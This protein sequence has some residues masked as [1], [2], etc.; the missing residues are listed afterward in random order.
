[1]NSIIITPESNIDN[2]L[3]VY[4]NATNFYFPEGKYYITDILNIDKPGI[5]FIGLPSDPK[6]VHIFQ[7]NSQKDGL[8][9][10]AD[11]F[12]IKFISIHV[13]HSGKVALQVASSNNSLFDS[14]YFYGNKT[15]FTVYFAGPKSLTEG[16]STL[17]GYSNNVLDTNNIFTNNVVYSQWS[18]DAVSYSLQ[19]RGQFSGNIIR[20]GKLAVYM[21]KSC[22]FFRNIIYDST[23]SSIH[24]S[25]PS[26]TI[27]IERN[28]IYECDSSG[29]KL[30]N[31]MEHGP[32]RTTPYNILIK[33]NYIYDAKKNAIELNDTDNCRISKNRL[34]SSD[35][36]G[37]YVLN[38][39]SI[40]ITENKVSYFMVAI[41]LE[42][43]CK[44][45]ITNNSFL[46]VYPNEGEN[47]VKLDLVSNDNVISGNSCKGKIIYDHYIVPSQSMNNT[48]ENNH[49]SEYYSIA[50]ERD[51]LG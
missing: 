12:T 35:K 49:Y 5:S 44:S 30:S 7:Q 38:S 16:R 23:D 45:T 22:G 17:N 24:V 18:G 33:N 41:W 47:I 36:F 25:L 48:L 21:C 31:Q 27:R 13:I 11:N 6:F 19:R 3:N 14:C 34:Y 20:G 32:F 50:E 4:P 43:G 37:I 46:S 51:I 2:L 42:N 40:T 9:V 1:M 29:I 28:T 15:T 10:I 8:N 39:K 26:H